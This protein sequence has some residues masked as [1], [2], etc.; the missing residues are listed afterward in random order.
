MPSPE[1]LA[2]SNDDR[3]PTETDLGPQDT[4]AD[5]PDTRDPRGPV[6]VP[7]EAP[8]SPLVLCMALA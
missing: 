1:G 6:T 8:S 3:I 4:A 5:A 2:A 7:H